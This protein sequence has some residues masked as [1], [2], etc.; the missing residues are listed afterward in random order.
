M[1]NGRKPS[2]SHRILRALLLKFDNE[3]EQ[4]GTQFAI[5][6]NN[7]T[8]N[9]LPKDK[10]QFRIQFI[11]RR[12]FNVEELLTFFDL[13]SCRFAFDGINLFTT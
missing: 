2:E 1:E 9:I 8:L 4:T 13:D 11:P 5:I 6:K 3:V 12:I 10:N 7:G